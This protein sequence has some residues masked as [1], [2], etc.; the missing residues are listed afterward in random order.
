MATLTSEID[1]SGPC[2]WPLAFADCDTTDLDSLSPE[3]RH[4][5]IRSAIEYL[6][7]WTGRVYGTCPAVIRPCREGCA[8][9]PTYSLSRLS[10][11]APVPPVSS[12]TPTAAAWTDYD[13]GCD[14]SGCCDDENARTLRLPGRVVSVES[15]TVDGA[16]L[17]PSTYRVD[18]HALLVR[19]D[20]GVW[21]TCQ[22]LTAHPSQPGTFQISYTRG[23]AVPYGGQLAAGVLATEMAKR[24][25]NNKACGLPTRVQSVTRQGVSMVVLEDRKS[26]V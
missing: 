23:A 12:F 9:V 16:V 4:T 21:P 25:C 8:Q 2:D 5:I 17:D 14:S 10:A 20:G 13:C 11:W 1:G 6:W 7:T 24:L 26:V 19:L 15:V 22:D 18:N 3:M